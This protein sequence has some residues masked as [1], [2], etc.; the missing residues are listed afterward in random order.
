MD[1]RVNQEPGAG[2]TGGQQTLPKEVAMK[3]SPEEAVGTPGQGQREALSSPAP[4]RPPSPWQLPIAPQSLESER[5]RPPP[6]PVCVSRAADAHC[7]HRDP[8]GTMGY[9]PHLPTPRRHCLGPAHGLPH[10]PS[11]SRCVCKAEVSSALGPPLLA[12]PVPSAPGWTSEVTEAVWTL[13]CPVPS[14]PPRGDTAVSCPQG[15]PAPG[16]WPSLDVA[17]RA[18]C[19]ALRGWPPAHLTRLPGRG[20]CPEGD[21]GATPVH[22]ALLVPYAAPAGPR[23]RTIPDIPN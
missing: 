7:K 16:P 17:G 20:G 2:V 10:P 13:P 5:D 8:L 12:G 18:L 11:P 14:P 19:M 22:S 23:V 4:P 6:C 21:S 15:C 1:Q 9:S 3:P